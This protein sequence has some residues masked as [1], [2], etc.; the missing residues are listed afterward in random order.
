LEIFSRATVNVKDL[1]GACGEYPEWGRVRHVLLRGMLITFSFGI[2]SGLSAV[3]LSSRVPLSR[4][5]LEI[6]VEPDPSSFSAI[7]L[8]PAFELPPPVNPSDTLASRRCDSVI[9]AHV[10]GLVDSEYIKSHKLGPPFPA[11]GGNR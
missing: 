6:R 8:A 11:S 5:N 9:P 2:D 10:A 3:Q 4:Y 7:A 1:S